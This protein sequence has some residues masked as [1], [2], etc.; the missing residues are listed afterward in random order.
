MPTQEPGDG[1]DDDDEDEDKDGHWWDWFYWW[2]SQ[3]HGRSH[4]GEGSWWGRK[5]T[6]VTGRP[7]GERPVEGRPVGGHW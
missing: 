6:E 7:V 4:S 3:R 5:R 2:K 1:D